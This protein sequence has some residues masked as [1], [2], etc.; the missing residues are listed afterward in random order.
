M[1]DER[2]GSLY[3]FERDRLFEAL[4]VALAPSG[5][6]Q[7]KLGL[8]HEN[9]V[10]GATGHRTH[11]WR[12]SGTGGGSRPIAVQH[13]IRAIPNISTWPVIFLAMTEARKRRPPFGAVV[14][15]LQQ[16]CSD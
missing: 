5:Q 8:A 11:E 10:A 9:R 15:V 4:P 14:S 13:E 7:K 1:R 12:S 16:Y 6:S 2:R 3:S